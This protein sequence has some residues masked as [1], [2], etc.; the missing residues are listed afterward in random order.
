MR[1]LR[2]TAGGNSCEK[3]TGHLGP[4]SI[5]VGGPGPVPLGVG[6]A[7]AELKSKTDGLKVG[8]LFL[9]IVG[10]PLFRGKYG[11]VGQFVLTKHGNEWHV[12]AEAD[13]SYGATR[14]LR[15]LN[16]LDLAAEMDKMVNGE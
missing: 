3:E 10:G 7:R 4:C 5:I 13:S 1:C 8:H 9:G 16:L 6:V 14:I 2:L 15:A 11:T 12:T